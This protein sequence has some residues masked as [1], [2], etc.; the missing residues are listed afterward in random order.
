MSYT[1]S[2]TDEEQIVKFEKKESEMLLKNY[3]LLENQGTY[4]EKSYLLK[5]EFL[6]AERYERVQGKIMIHI[7]F[8]RNF[9]GYITNDTRITYDQYIKGTLICSGIDKIAELPHKSKSDIK[10]SRF[11]KYKK[12]TVPLLEEAILY[13]KCKK[14]YIDNVDIYASHENKLMLDDEYRKIL[15]KAFENPD[16][17]IGLTSSI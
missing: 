4:P 15:K 6:S 2:L 8:K 5:P 1:K 11:T 12:L 10:Q 9:A 13:V 16:I 7:Q 14:I 3:D 17:K